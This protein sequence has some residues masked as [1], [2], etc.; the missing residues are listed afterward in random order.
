MNIKYL[1]SNESIISEQPIEDVALKDRLIEFLS[2]CEEIVQYEDEEIFYSLYLY[3]QKIYDV[4]FA[5][6][7]YADDNELIEEEKKLFRILM[8]QSFKNDDEL[9]IG[10]T[11]EGY[12]ASLYVLNRLELAT[13]EDISVYEKQDCFKVRR[14]FLH[15]EK[16]REIIFHCLSRAFPNLYFSESVENSLKHFN[17]ISKHVEE[18]L[19]HLAALDNYAM[20]LFEKYS[21][22]GE[23]KVL[24]VLASMAG[25]ICSPEGNPDTVEQYLHF[26]FKDKNGNIQ[27]ISCSPHTKLYRPDSN[28]R[29]YFTWNKGRLVDLPA[30]LVGHIGNHPY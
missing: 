11:V 10:D 14:W 2:V 1:L 24:S 15:K 22:E 13:L 9:Q 3:S 30:I 8:Q 17:P 26:Q 18:L 12:V 25:I 16:D 27:L 5:D 29:I 28:Y 4:E 23:A 21:N 7:L 6:W 19:K 20:F